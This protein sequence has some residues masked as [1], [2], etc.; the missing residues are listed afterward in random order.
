[1]KYLFVI[2]ALMITILSNA[3][4]RLGSKAKDIFLEFE[5]QGIEYSGTK[6]EMYLVYYFND[7]LIIQYYF[8]KD[9]ICD[10]VL[11][12]TFNQEMTDFLF[13][14]YETRGYLKT[15]EGWLPRKNGIIYKIAHQ[16]E[17][18]GINYF[19]WY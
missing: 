5:E 15:N 1:M 19:L 6:D 3:Q 16:V 10:K 7:N 12:Q 18:D 13:D 11:I 2:T 9:S 4:S 17:K 14:T 8:D